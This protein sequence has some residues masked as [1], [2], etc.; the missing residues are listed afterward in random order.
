VSKTILVDDALLDKYRARFELNARDWQDPIVR[1]YVLALSTRL[2]IALMAGWDAAVTDIAAT[3]A[4][5]EPLHEI[6][7][8]EYGGHVLWIA[9]NWYCVRDVET[10]RAAIEA[11]C[12]K[13]PEDGRLVRMRDVVPPSA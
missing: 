6:C 10:T 13:W 11:A 2:T 3:L 4:R 8:Y 1:G 7:E 12:R 5:F 9:F